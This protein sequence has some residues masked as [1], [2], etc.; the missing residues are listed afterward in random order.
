MSEPE[1][2]ILGPNGWVPNNSVL[3]VLIYRGVVPS[4]DPDAIEAQLLRNAWRP[5]WRDGV[6]SYH[7]YHS[8][9]HEALACSSGK[10]ELMLGG[11]GGR[12]VQIEAGDL[13]VLPVGTGHCRIVASDDFLLVGAYP[14]GQGW[15]VCR[16][17]ADRATLARIAAVPLPKGD[18]IDG[19]N[20]ALTRLWSKEA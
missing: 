14:Q 2:L 10:A 8:T 17:A 12:Q 20:G 6:Y 4:G 18:T 15:D 13:L 19:T 5:D 7:H 11:E 9:A 1:T 16:T 3:P